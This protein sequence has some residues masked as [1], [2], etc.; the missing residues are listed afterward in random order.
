MMPRY[1]V[2]WRVYVY[3][4]SLYSLPDS[5]KPDFREWSPQYFR[6]NSFEIHRIMNW[7]NRDA[8]VLLKSNKTDVFLVYE[9]ILSLLTRV[10]IKS[11]EFGSAVVNYFGV[12]T[13]QFIHELMN[14]ARSPYDDII[15]YECNT[16]YRH[17]PEGGASTSAMARELSSKL[18]NF[19]E[20]SRSINYDDCGG[21]EADLALED[22]DY[23]ELGEMVAERLNPPF[24][25]ETDGEMVGPRGSQS[26]SLIQSVTQVNHSTQSQAAAQGQHQ[27]AQQAQ[28]RGQ[29]ASQPGHQHAST[30]DSLQLEDLEL[31]VAIERSI[32]E[33]VAA[34]QGTSQASAQ[35][36][37]Q[38]A[39]QGSELH[40]PSE[41]VLP[42]GRVL[43]LAHAASGRAVR[44]ASGSGVVSAQPP[45]AAVSGGSTAFAAA[46]TPA[47]ARSSG[48]QGRRRRPP[49]AR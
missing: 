26:H 6:R 19:V 27:A 14:F 10:S 47:Q 1:M 35:A 33:G 39:S 4:N 40:L 8:S 23:G 43:H 25:V 44:N 42:S 45:Q 49:R 11:L 30:S 46:Q 17:F 38:G 36:T 28:Q 22:E 15:S 3:A 32:F 18:Y 31:E 2:K 37:A 7:V 21:F 16:M 12:K 9:V 48:Q 20:F 29:R 5:I 34:A 13:H 24:V 41:F